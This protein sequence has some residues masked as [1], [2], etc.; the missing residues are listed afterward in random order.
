MT[1]K[2]LQEHEK[3]HQKA[4][5]AELHCE[6]CDET[7]GLEIEF[8]GHIGIVH[9]NNAL[10]AQYKARPVRQRIHEE[11]PA[12][13]FETA[14]STVERSTVIKGEAKACRLDFVAEEPN[15]LFVIEVD[16]DQHR[17]SYYTIKMDSLRP[18][19]VLG[20]IEMK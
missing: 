2:G 17:G 13:Y 9:G 20:A 6:V 19:K 3:V 1:E 10:R 8:Y 5:G 16:E 12:K 18:R 14:L 7:F 11:A 15:V 4:G